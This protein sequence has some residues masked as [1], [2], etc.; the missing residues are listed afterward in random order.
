MDVIDLIDADALRARFSTP[1]AMTVGLEEEVMVLDP[2]TLDLA[3]R[4]DA[5]LAAVDGDRRFKREMPAAQLEAV[6]AP[7][8]DVATALD[9]L[10]RARTDLAAVAARHG[11]LRL[12]GAGVHPF[13]AGVGALN[14]SATYDAMQAEFGEIARRQ[15]VFGLHV[16]VAVGNAERAV[17][18]H[19]AMREH[20][21]D[22]AALAANAPFYEGADSGLA[23]VRPVLSDLLPRQGPPPALGSV[24]GW[25]ET[26]RWGR[27]SGALPR[28][29]R[30]WWELRLNHNFGT[31]EVRVPDTQA[32]VAETGAVAEVV[33]RL[34]CHLAAR[35]DAG[36]LPEPAAEWRVRENRW[37][38]LRHGVDGRLADLRSGRSRPAAERLADL[39]DEIGAP[40][41]CRTLLTDP[42]ARRARDVA[43]EA[44]VRG[45][46]ESLTER[47]C[48]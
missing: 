16:H 31:L 33:H 10:S 4:A 6:T 21:P 34:I 9:E 13:A 29:E 23:S 36:D 38:A 44:G 43:R 32:T 15:L 3:P 17:A 28:G 7:H 2:D 41:S 47:F 18:V 11:G 1:V 48:G 19:D 5:V 45:L 22:L 30:W 27:A 37:S 46:V 8:L 35:H 26:L 14:A 12:A 39:M 42:P 25:A 40:A 20:L 24:E